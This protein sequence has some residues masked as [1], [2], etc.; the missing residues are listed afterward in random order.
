MDELKQLR[1]LLEKEREERKKETTSLWYAMRRLSAGQSV[2]FPPEVAASS[3]AEDED[4][5]SLFPGEAETEEVGSTD[6]LQQILCGDMDPPDFAGLDVR[7]TTGEEATGGAP[8]LSQ[9]QVCTS[10]PAGGMPA[11]A[12]RRSAL[13]VGDSM[14]H[15]GPFRA[16]KSLMDLVFLG[17]A[18]G[19]MGRDGANLHG[20]D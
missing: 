20:P 18:W 14:V 3:L 8:K 19:H 1:V 4:E 15:H 17:G 16:K 2:T 6:I 9:G 12:E 5:T 13:V 7:R 11:A 10:G